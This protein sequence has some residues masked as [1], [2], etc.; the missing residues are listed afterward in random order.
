M[1]AEAVTESGL[2]EVVE[3]EVPNPSETIVETPS[4][5]TPEE[6][7]VLSPEVQALLDE[8]SD[9]AGGTD[10][11]A[12]GTTEQ[13]P[14][15][16]AEIEAAAEARVIQRLTIQGQKQ[17]KTNEV[18]GVRRSFVAMDADLQ[19]LQRELDAAYYAAQSTGDNTA[20]LDV[21]RRMKNRIDQHNGH[22]GTLYHNDVLEAHNLGSNQV[23][24][25]IHQAIEAQ[26]G[27]GEFE[28]LQAKHE[29][30]AGV[31]EDYAERYAKK[32]GWKAASE[33]KA[34]ENK[35]HIKAMKAFEK[36]TGVRLPRG[37]TDKGIPI[38]QGS[39]GGLR[40]GTVEWAENASVPELLAAKAR[41]AY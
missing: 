33:V 16:E 28:D 4:V 3:Q 27:K 15:T 14:R 11:T 20:V 8:D 32:K 31:L 22:W 1:V 34:A 25:W 21:Q 24:G 29:E 40:V 9:G 41:G 13:K 35:A 19:I 2:P 37:D 6:E 38:A 10:A 36:I 7:Y 17:A 30:W 23:R 18:E 26:L 39:A 12:Q 5:E